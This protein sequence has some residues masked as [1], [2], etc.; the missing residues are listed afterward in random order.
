MSKMR[1]NEVLSQPI[2]FSIDESI[3]KTNEHILAIAKGEFFFPD[4]KSRNGRYYPKK[5]W[6]KTLSSPETQ[7]RLANRTMFGAMGHNVELTDETIGEGVASH[8]MAN[9]R[10]EEKD[11][12]LQGLGEAYILNTPRGRVLNTLLRAGCKIC[13]SSRADGSYTNETFDGLDVVDPETYQFYG[14]DFIIDPGFI[15][16]MPTITETLKKDIDSLFNSDEKNNNKGENTM[17][18]EAVLEKVTNERAQFK[19]DLERALDENKKAMKEI[20]NSRSEVARVTSELTSAKTELEKL[21]GEKKEVETKLADTTKVVESYKGFGAVDEVSKAFDTAKARISSYKEFG[22]P[23]LINKAMTMAERE[24]K[25]LR[26]EIAV[27]DKKVKAFESIGTVEQLQ[28]MAKFSNKLLDKVITE[29]EGEEVEALCVEFEIEKDKIQKLMD[30]G[31]SLE[32]IKK[33]IG[34]LAEAPVEVE[35]SDEEGE[36]HGDEGSEEGEESPST[37]DKFEEPTSEVPMERKVK[38]S[39]FDDDNR[40]SSIAEGFLRVLPK[41]KN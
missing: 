3:N 41:K 25:K 14:F 16:A 38:K 31:L 11:G 39:R 4:G 18:L 19:T 26:A 32:Q 40:T 2:S 33:V 27:A 13:T 34:S 12:R 23:E 24:I 8:F 7:T 9:L 22:T 17:S 37:L 5:L 1:L 28:K 35:T 20:E 29:E 15:K 21:I 36:E 6:E 30:D 10:M